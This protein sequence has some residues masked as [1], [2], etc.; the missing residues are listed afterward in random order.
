M[1]FGLQKPMVIYKPLAEV[2]DIPEDN[3]TYWHYNNAA[4]FSDAFGDCLNELE[5]KWGQRTR[6]RESEKKSDQVEVKT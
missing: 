4:S 2:C 3:A 6:R 1:G 5:R